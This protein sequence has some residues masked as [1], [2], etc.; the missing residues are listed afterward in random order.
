M[1]VAST[2]LYALPS[3]SGH[4]PDEMMNVLMRD[5][6]LD[7]RASVNPS[8]PS[9]PLSCR[10]STHIRPSIVLHQNEPRSHCGSIWSKDLIV[11]PTGNEGTSGKHLEVC[12]ALQAYASPDPGSRTFFTVSPDSLISVTYAQCEPALT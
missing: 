6:L 4:A 3:M 5:L 10:D 9:M 2:C 7:L 11:V 12:V 8:I 1:C